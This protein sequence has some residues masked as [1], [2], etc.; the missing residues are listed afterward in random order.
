MLA[1]PATSTLTHSIQ[2]NYHLSSY[3]IF[4]SHLTFSYITLNTAVDWSVTVLILSINSRILSP[5]RWYASW[6]PFLHHL[7]ERTQ[8]TSQKS[9]PTEIYQVPNLPKTS[10]PPVSSKTLGTI[11]ISNEFKLSILIPSENPISSQ[12]VEYRVSDT[13]YWYA[14]SRNSKF[15]L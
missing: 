12:Y 14:T 10:I 13:S 9:A 11:L 2:L 1:R 15:L 7:V 5:S 3:P 6:I 8:H 4:N